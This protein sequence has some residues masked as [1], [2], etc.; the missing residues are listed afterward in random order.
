[1]Y[2]GILFIEM[3][4]KRRYILFAILVTDESIGILCPLF[5]FRLSDDSAVIRSLLE[6][7]ILLSKRQAAASVRGSAEDNV[8]HRPV[9]GFHQSFVRVLNTPLTETVGHPIRNTPAFVTG[10][11]L[12]FTISKFRCSLVGS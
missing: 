9:L 7:H 3:R 2:M 4:N 5:N 6:I 1:M 12:P 10:R 8:D 11:T